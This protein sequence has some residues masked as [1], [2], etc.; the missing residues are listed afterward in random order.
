[1]ENIDP[2]YN[3]KGV[4]QRFFASE[5]SSRYPRYDLLGYDQV[6]QLLSILQDPSSIKV[7]EIWL[8]IQS[9]VSFQPSI[10]HSGYENLQVNVVRK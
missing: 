5:P 7:E 2:P 6:K 4:Y 1:L 10:V 8:G 3:Y 9:N